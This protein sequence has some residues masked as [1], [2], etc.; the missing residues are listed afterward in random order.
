MAVIIRKLDNKEHEYFT[1]VKSLCGHRTYFLYFQDDIWESAVPH[2]FIEILRSFLNSSKVT[3]TL[4]ENDFTLKNDAL[5][6]LLKT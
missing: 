1:Y 2:T 6:E 5:L 4:A 3:V